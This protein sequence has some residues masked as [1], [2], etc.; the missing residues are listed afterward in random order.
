M[1]VTVI[2]TTEILSLEN[3]KRL[4]FP[5][6]TETSRCNK[7][8]V[9]IS[10]CYNNSKRIVCTK[11]STTKNKWKALNHVYLVHVPIYM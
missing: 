4:C 3:G 1:P 7:P 10:T 11:K 9:K 2:A 6:E 8:K 5:Q